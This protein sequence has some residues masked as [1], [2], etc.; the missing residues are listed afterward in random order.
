MPWTSMTTMRRE[1]HISVSRPLLKAITTLSFGSSSGTSARSCFS[2]SVGWT[3]DA[4]ASQPRNCFT[5]NGL[6]GITAGPWLRESTTIVASQ[7]WMVKMS[8]ESFRNSIFS[9]DSHGIWVQIFSSES[10][11][12]EPA[13]STSKERTDRYGSVVYCTRFPL[14]PCTSIIRM[15]WVVRTTESRPN[16]KATRTC[17][18]GSRTGADCRSR[19]SAPWGSTCEACPLRRSRKP[20]PPAHCCCELGTARAAMQAL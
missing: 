12:K 14:M 3:W 5:P 7:A 20:V 11:S 15:R 4:P 17:S 9:F 8:T 18:S 19:P 10:P 6:E 1:V 13:D 16:L 2:S